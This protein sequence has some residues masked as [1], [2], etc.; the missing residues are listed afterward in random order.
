M[1]D[2]WAQLSGNDGLRWSSLYES[3]KATS[4]YNAVPLGYKPSIEPN[5]YGEGPLEVTAGNDNFGVN[6]QF[7]EAI[8]D[9]VGVRE[10][11]VNDG[12]GTGVTTGSAVIR[13]SNHTRVSALNSYGYLMSGRPN[14]RIFPRAWV[15]RI[16]FDGTTATGVEY[17]RDNSIFGSL[18]SKEVIVSAGAIG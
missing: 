13:A 8:K 1:F 2:E 4:R 9:V 6:L 10:I 14:A 5:V 3:F 17:V 18:A 7:V 15:T 11:D 12:E 16:M